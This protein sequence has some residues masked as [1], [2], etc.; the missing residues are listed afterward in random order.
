MS[1]TISV[2]IDGHGAGV[3]FSAA[4]FLIDH[5]KCERVHGHNY[6]VSA[7]A[8]GAMDAGGMVLDFTELKRALR[9]VVAGLDHHVILPRDGSLEPYHRGGEVRFEH[10]GR[11]YSFP[12]EDVAVLEVPAVTAEHIAAALLE[13]LRSELD[14]RG[15]TSLAVGVEEGPGQTAWARATL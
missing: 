5:E 4:H 1:R 9:A 7:V 13:R 6:I 8:E 15:L 14:V 11:E 2:E 3:H 12:A 10:H